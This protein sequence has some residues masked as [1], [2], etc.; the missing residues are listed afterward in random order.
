MK[1]EFR[2]PDVGEGIAE[3]EI[4]EWLVEVGDRIGEDHVV[5]MIQTDKSVV[6]MPSPVAGVVTSLGG[7]PGDILP[8]GEV[9]IV[10]DA[11]DGSAPAIPPPATPVAQAPSAEVAT[12]SAQPATRPR[13]APAVRK[14]ALDHGVDL[15]AV[16]GTGPGG[17]ITRDDVLSAASATTAPEERASPAPV[18]ERPPRPAAARPEGADERV[19]LRG[20][21][22]QIAKKMVEAWQTVPHIIDYREADATRLV[23]ARR[24]LREA[25]PERASSLTYV[26][27]LTKIT[28][29]ALHEHP[30]LNA[31]LDMEAQEYVLQQRINI[32]IATSTDDG[33]LVPVVQDADQRSVLEI[34]EEIDALVTRTRAGKATRD[35][36]AGG[37]YTVNNLGALGTT[38]GTPIIRTPEVGIIGFGRITD[39]VV[40][41]DGVP[42]VR[43]TMVLSSVGDH[44]LLD[45]DTLSAFTASVVRLIESPY[46][47]LA[48]L[49]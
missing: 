13:A 26:P 17:R 32:G 2:V 48:D 6:E 39:R 40:A 41:V 7:Q 47:L 27:V 38:M 28:A 24:Q 36:L 8:V 5:A 9:L 37:T 30:L 19:P 45:G 42:T 49:R 22:R 14:V 1:V 18:A 10:V 31:S 34:A 16:T 21:R 3:I 25:L 4:I 44:R 12:A 15:T 33:L 20:L 11:P 43:P 23:E 46:L 35:D 29:I